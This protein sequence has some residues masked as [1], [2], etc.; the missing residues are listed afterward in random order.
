MLPLW[1]ARTNLDTGH[2]DRVPCCIKISSVQPERRYGEKFASFIHFTAL[3]PRIFIDNFREFCSSQARA[4]VVPFAACRPKKD[5]SCP[6][7]A[8][9]A[10]RGAVGGVR[11]QIKVPIDCVDLPCSLSQPEAPSVAWP[12]A[13][14]APDWKTQPPP[15]NCF[16]CPW[17]IYGLRSNNNSNNNDSGPVHCL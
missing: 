9:W 1:G 5:N 12:G 2:W 10:N 15:G 14:P 13:T 7:A 11:P 3:G 17:S 16:D 8:K 6:H 4:E